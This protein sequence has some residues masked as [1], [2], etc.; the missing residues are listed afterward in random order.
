MAKKN[1]VDLIALILVLAGALNI[2]IVS[3]LSYDVLAL[4]GATINNVLGI[5]IGIAALYMI[6]GA[7]K[8]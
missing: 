3:I 8:K 4:L 2:G 5:L 1:N 6:Y 7:V